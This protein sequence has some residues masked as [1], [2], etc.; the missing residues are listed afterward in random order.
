MMRA[1]RCSNASLHA[2]AERKEKGPQIKA[3]TEG[4]ALRARQAMD[5]WTMR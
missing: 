4:R 2:P 1:P 5:M 3:A